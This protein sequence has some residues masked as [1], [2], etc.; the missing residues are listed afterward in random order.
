[1]K[2][3]LEEKIKKIEK[4]ISLLESKKRY[5]QQEIEKI[6]VEEWKKKREEG[7]QGFIFYS[8]YYGS[9]CGVDASKLFYVFAPTAN[10]D[11]ERWKNV[12]FSHGDSTESETNKE[13]EKELKKLSDSDYDYVDDHIIQAV[14]P[15]LY[16]TYKRM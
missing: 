5:F 13:F 14:W 11:I 1:M 7:W 4:T 8:S 9:E 2:K 6:E 3:I 15:E 10:I 12:E 16:E